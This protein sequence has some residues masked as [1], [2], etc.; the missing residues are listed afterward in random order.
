MPISGFV[1]AFFVMLR[2]SPV[3]LGGKVV[4]FSGLSL[5]TLNAVAQLMHGVPPREKVFAPPHSL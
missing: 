2:S 4:V 3:S 1:L 5:Q